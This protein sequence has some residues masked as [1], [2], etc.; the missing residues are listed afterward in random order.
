MGVKRWSLRFCCE[1]VHCWG[2][3]DLGR[4]DIAVALTAVFV[5]LEGQ[6]SLPR[7]YRFDEPNAT[8]EIFNS[9]FESVMTSCEKGS[10]FIMPPCGRNKASL[11]VFI[12][13]F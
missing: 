6:K 2:Y 8:L 5:C 7:S 4:V 3:E 11:H 10:I 9:H 12:G 1:A 13:C